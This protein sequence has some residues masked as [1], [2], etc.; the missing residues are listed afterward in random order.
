MWLC[1]QVLLTKLFNWWQ[2]HVWAPPL[3]FSEA[4][5]MAALLLCHLTAVTVL[6]HLTAVSSVH[7]TRGYMT[8]R[9]TLKI[10]VTYPPDFWKGSFGMEDKVTLTGNKWAHHTTWDHTP[11]HTASSSS[12]FTT[13]HFLWR[14]RQ[15]TRTMN[16]PLSCLQPELYRIHY[17]L[18]NLWTIALHILFIRHL[19]YQELWD[20]HSIY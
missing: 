15:C 12:T 10:T 18:I 3:S 13:C 11:Q 5:R 4:I 9:S 1:A 2:W 19:Y 7:P 14:H 16:E 8:N 20:T 17:V 6:C